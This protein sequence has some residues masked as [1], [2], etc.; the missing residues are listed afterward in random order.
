MIWKILN[1]LDKVQSKGGDR[2][3]ACCPAHEDSDPSLT[4]AET[5]DGRILIHCFAG[6]APIDILNAIGLTMSDLFPDGG[7][8]DFK[9]WDQLKREQEARLK[10]K[11]IQ[12]VSHD[13]IILDMCKTA[14]KNGERLS[15]ADLQREQQAYFRVRNANIDR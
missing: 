8:G 7:L 14:R 15:K 11:K 1:L 4:L 12:A 13:Q 9:G 2:Y 6:C 10:D 5:K 3:V